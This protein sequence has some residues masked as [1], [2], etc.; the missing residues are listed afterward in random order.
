MVSYPLVI[1]VGYGIDEVASDH[2]TISRFGSL[3]T[4]RGAYEV[5]FKHI[6]SQLEKRAIIIKQGALVDASII[7]TP[8]KP[9]GK[10]TYRVAEDRAD[11]EEREKPTH[12]VAKERESKEVEK[13]VPSSVDS[14]GAWSRKVGKLS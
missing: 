6:N 5:M 13:F 7:D 10:S 12:E 2:S 9:K 11:R 8:L 1:S 3:M 14:D 4:K